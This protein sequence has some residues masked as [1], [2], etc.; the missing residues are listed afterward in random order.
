MP[1]DRDPLDE[2]LGSKTAD[3][4]VQGAFGGWWSRADD[5]QK[6]AVSFLTASAVL[7]PLGMGLLAALK[8]LFSSA[9]IPSA[10]QLTAVGWLFV[11]TLPVAVG[12][13]VFTALLGRVATVPLVAAV[14]AGVYFAGAGMATAGIPE[15]LGSFY[16]YAGFDGSGIAYEAA[17]RTYDSL[18]FV[19]D[20]PRPQGAATTPEI[21][22][23][24]IIY[25]AEARGAVMVMCSIV[26]AACVGYLIRRA[27]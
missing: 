27:T 10:S 9:S 4:A 18:G 21:F 16:C 6:L 3:A 17:C 22:Q 13:L 23:W 7:G 20:A 2:A 12:V 15:H 24:A 1:D 8:V 11:I 5:N 26:A 19:R 14:G 25:T